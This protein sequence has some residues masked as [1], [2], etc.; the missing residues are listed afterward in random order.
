MTVHVPR[1]D[2]IAKQDLDVDLVVRTVD[3]AG[4]V[5]GIRVDAAAGKRVLDAAR[6]GG[7]EIAA[8][9]HH[10]GAH[11]P[12]IDAHPVVGPVADAG[13]AFQ[14]CLDVGADPPV[15]QQLDIGL[16]HGVDEFRRRQR[17]L[18]DTKRLASSGATG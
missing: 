3:A 1:L 4:V 8:L 6:L 7:A 10:P 14:G 15:P 2:D 16:Q 11:L 18:G 17:L 13:M 5:D 12:A 9:A